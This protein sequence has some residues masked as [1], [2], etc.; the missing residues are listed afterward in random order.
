MGRWGEGWGLVL[1]IGLSACTIE[2]T[3]RALLDRRQAGRQEAQEAVAELRTYVLAAVRAV[4]RGDL[5]TAETM[6]NPDTP[7]TVLGPEPSAPGASDGAVLAPLAEAAPLAVEALTVSAD[8]RRGWGWFA[9]RLRSRTGSLWLWSGV[10][11]REDGGAWRLVATS[12]GYGTV[13]VAERRD[14]GTRTTAG[15]RHQ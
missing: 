7:L 1:A 9:A 4:D 3:P 8:V 14:A 2:P 6:L 13:S 5:R 15:E 11:R 10:Y 12:L